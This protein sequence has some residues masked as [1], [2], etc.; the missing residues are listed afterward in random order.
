MEVAVAN[1]AKITV[2]DL[3]F[4]YGNISK[5]IIRSIKEGL[6]ILII[7]IIH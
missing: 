3:N 7:L 5:F 1:K 4:Y 6:K 2:K